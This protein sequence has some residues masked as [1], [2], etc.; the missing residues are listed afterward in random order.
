L[1][2]SF[3]RNGIASVT[4]TIQFQSNVQ[5]DYDCITVKATRIKMGQINAGTCVEK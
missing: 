4:G 2:F 3:N 1:D 5:P